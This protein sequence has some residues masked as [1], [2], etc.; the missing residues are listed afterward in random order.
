MLGTTLNREFALCQLSRKRPSL[1]KNFKKQVL[2]HYSPTSH[3]A[4]APINILT[5]I[6][7]A[8]CQMKHREAIQLGRQRNSIEVFRVYGFFKNG[9]VQ[10]NIRR[11][12]TQQQANIASKLI[13]FCIRI[14]ANNKM[15]D[16][17]VYL[18]LL[19]GLYEIP[20]S[21]DIFQNFFT[22]SHKLPRWTT[23]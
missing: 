22:F 13:Q 2:L 3:Y 20:Q 14:F 8:A 15:A 18:L 17:Q 6:K 9:Q 16:F 19:Y 1:S 10:K 11:D 5:F 23:Q 4:S 21:C 12:N 7:V